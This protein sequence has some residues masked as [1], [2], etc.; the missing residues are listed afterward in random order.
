MGLAL[1]ASL[2]VGFGFSVPPGARECFEEHAADGDHV[3]GSWS[4]KHEE[5]S[6]ALS[7]WKVTGTLAALCPCALTLLH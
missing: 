6:P 1:L 4:V 7:G 3:L 5:S 2:S